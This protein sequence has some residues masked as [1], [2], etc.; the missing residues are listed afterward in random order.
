MSAFGMPHPVFALL[1]LP[2]LA[3]AP[4][5]GASSGAAP[6]ATRVIELFTSQGCSSCPPADRLMQ[7]LAGQPDTIVLS[8]PVDYWDYIGWKDTFAS[9]AYTARQKAYA[10]ARGD[11]SVYT[12]QAVVNGLRHAVG[13]DPVEI[14]AA[15]KLADGE[16]GAMRV[17]L[18][19]HMEGGHLVAEVGAAPEG[20]GKWGAFWVLRVSKSRSVAIGRGENAGHTVTYTNVVRGMDKAGNWMGVPARFEID[21]MGLKQG[22]SDGY[23]LLLQA[24]QGPKLGAILA[25]AKGPGL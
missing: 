25:A 18:K 22:D 15:T 4:A 10:Q 1:A 16:Q 20:A 23:V 17:P 19:T 21:E 13:S 5:V 6:V 9:P 24:N 8:F 11:G 12:P 3:S 2:A 7:S 14:D